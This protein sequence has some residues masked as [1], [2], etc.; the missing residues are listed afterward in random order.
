MKR[1]V[2]TVAV[3][4]PSD[5]AVARRLLEEMGLVAGPVHGG[6][7]KHWLDQQMAGFNNAARYQPW[8]VLRDFDRD[9]SCP[10]ELVAKL[11]PQ[12]SPGMHLR[13]AVRSTEAWLLADRERIARFLSVS[14][15]SVPT[16]PDNLPDPKATMINLARRSRLRAIHEDMVPASGLTVRVGRAYSARLAEFAA[17][18]W[19]P[20]EAAKSSQS[21]RRCMRALSGLA[22]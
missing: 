1:V 4:G 5:E 10:P 9:A 16:E 20:G 8:L 15:A 21:L 17:G 12:P 22:A 7:G 18:P 13:F 19:R 6:R 2:V 14:A 3:E 11:M